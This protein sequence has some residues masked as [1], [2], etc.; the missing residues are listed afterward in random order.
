MDSPKGNITHME[1]VMSVRIGLA[2]WFCLALSGGSAVAQDKLINTLSTDQVE[3][4]LKGLNLEF[5]KLTSKTEGNF[6]YDFTLARKHSARLH[7]YKGKDI[8]SEEHTS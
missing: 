3:Q 5:K 4:M 7:Y 1:V 2:L 8:R 6:F